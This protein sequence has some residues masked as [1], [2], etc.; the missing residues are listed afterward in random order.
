[1]GFTEMGTSPL[2]ACTMPV[3]DLLAVSREKYTGFTVLL[4]NTSSA[5]RIVE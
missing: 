1:M 3:P 2:T 4:R 5:C